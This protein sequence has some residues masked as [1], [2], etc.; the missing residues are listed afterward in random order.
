[1][2]FKEIECV[3]IAPKRRRNSCARV[4]VRSARRESTALWSS[5]EWCDDPQSWLHGFAVSE[6][7][8][9]GIQ[10]RSCFRPSVDADVCAELPNFHGVKK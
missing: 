3:V 4:D 10:S 8:T 9:F 6:K 1:M 2:R 5:C 7:H